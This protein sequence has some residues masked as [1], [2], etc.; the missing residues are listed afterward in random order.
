MKNNRAHEVQL[1]EWIAVFRV[2]HLLQGPRDD[3]LL[4]P[5]RCTLAA[6]PEKDTALA[7][8]SGAEHH[9]SRRRPPPTGQLQPLKD[10]GQPRAARR[11]RPR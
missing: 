7:S 5:L 8:T 2:W 6:C 1:E 10:T 3:L 9:T 11:P 4:T